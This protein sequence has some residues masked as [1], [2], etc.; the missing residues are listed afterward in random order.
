MSN[1]LKTTRGPVPS[2]LGTRT[3]RP[4][5]GLR[6]SPRGPS[7][8]GGRNRP[9]TPPDTGEKGPE[10]SLG[11]VVGPSRENRRVVGQTETG[12]CTLWSVVSPGPGSRRL[13][14][15]TDNSDGPPDRVLGHTTDTCTPPARVGKGVSPRDSWTIPAKRRCVVRVQNVYSL[16]SGSPHSPQEC[17]WVVPRPPRPLVW[18]QVTVLGRVRPHLVSRPTPRLPD[19]IRRDLAL[20]HVFP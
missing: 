1:N 5:T 14:G 17:Q 6:R 16:A 15:P 18:V 20:K 8:A 10:E 13:P 2:G 19:L 4:W 9:P 3:P 11:G 12:R 7:T